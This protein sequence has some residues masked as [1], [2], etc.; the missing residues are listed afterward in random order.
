MRTPDKLVKLSDMQRGFTLIELA[1][2]L[3]IIGLLIGG[4]TSGAKMIESARL[5]NIAS[6]ARQLIL[7]TE[8]FKSKYGT[9]PGDFPNASALWGSGTCTAGDVNLAT[10]STN[11]DG[12]GDGILGG[13]DPGCNAGCGGLGS[14][15][16]TSEGSLVLQHLALAKLISGS[17]RG[18]INAFTLGT[19]AVPT[20]LS[21]TGFYFT[22]TVS[23][24]QDYCLRQVYGFTG[25]V[26]ILSK[27]YING[28]VGA[29]SLTVNQTSALD[30]KIDDGAPNTGIFLGYS[31]RGSPATFFDCA[32]G[33]TAPF[34]YRYDNG[35][36]LACNGAWVLP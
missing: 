33:P 25:N 3:T 12:N 18:G 10:Y 21:D 17:Y 29:V 2:V 16:G 31:G 15:D 23:A 1:I 19:T 30:R 14:G 28:Q 11:C 7:T 32:T 26:L 5:Q 35:D 9:L 24:F 13:Y 20:V 6:Q 36:V 8:I 22:S 34:T 27:G 4:I